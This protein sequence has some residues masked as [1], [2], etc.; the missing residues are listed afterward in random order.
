MLLDFDIIIVDTETSGLKGVPIF[1]PNNRLI[2][3]SALHL[4]TGEKF[5]RYLSYGED[6]IIPPG[7]IDIH[8]IKNETLKTQGIPAKDALI[9]F[10][11]WKNKFTK[12]RILVAHK[13]SFDET[14]I[15]IA[16]IREFGKKYTALNFKEEWLCTLILFK[17]AYPNLE[18]EIEPKDQPYSLGKL[19]YT[20]LNKTFKD[21]HNSDVDVKALSEMFKYAIEKELV[22]STNYKQ[23]LLPPPLP[24]SSLIKDVPNF[25]DKRAQLISD[26]LNHVFKEENIDLKVTSNLVT[27]GHLVVY[28]R[29]R[30]KHYLKTNPIINTNP[31][32]DEWLCIAHSI[33]VMLRCPPFKICCLNTIANLVA[34]VLGITIVEF[35]FYI[36]DDLF[37]MV[38][39]NK[40]AYLHLNL[41]DEQSDQLYKMT[42]WKDTGDVIADYLMYKK[43]SKE[44]SKFH[45]L[46]FAFNNHYNPTMDKKIDYNKD[47]SL[48]HPQLSEENKNNQE[49]KD[50]QQQYS[51]PL[52]PPPPVLPVVVVAAAAPLVTSSFLTKQKKLLLQETQLENLSTY[53]G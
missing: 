44:K 6:F 1:H 14:I 45:K 9:E 29:S 23:F 21:M 16:Y 50:L 13:A 5:N 4:N 51:H 30:Y 48:H 3:I 22:S 53:L 24:R 2:Q 8:H 10:D 42:G 36:K 7:S 12:P 20:F 19:C 33:E 46:A 40:L 27:I 41:T 26:H 43:E 18:R 35:I 15:R 39:G 11:K 52:P 31:N 37:P 38:R 25:R 49:D 47:H 32:I 17:K 34:A 28:G